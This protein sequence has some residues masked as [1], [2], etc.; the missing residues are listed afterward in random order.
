MSVDS[1]VSRAIN[2]AL[3]R[4]GNLDVEMNGTNIFLNERQQNEV[5]SVAKNRTD[6][7]K[8][9]NK[10]YRKGRS[11]DLVLYF[12]GEHVFL[13]TINGFAK[14]GG[15]MNIDG[16]GRFMFI[17]APPEGQRVRHH[18]CQL[19]ADRYIKIA[20]VERVVTSPCNMYRWWFYMVH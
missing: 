10:L 18:V 2:E 4:H 7:A 17:R 9:F 3:Q 8:T 5:Q 12:T 14:I 11:G 13:H 16:F 19:S 6:N 1:T 15:L 20:P